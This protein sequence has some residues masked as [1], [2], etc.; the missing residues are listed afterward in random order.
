MVEMQSFDY[1]GN[2]ISSGQQQAYEEHILLWVERDWLMS[3]CE[4]RGKAAEQD[5]IANAEMRLLWTLLA[6]E[7]ER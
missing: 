5:R 7:N 3:C 4:T 1:G 2:S 6:L